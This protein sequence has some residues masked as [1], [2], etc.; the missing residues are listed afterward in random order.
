MS[1]DPPVPSSS[2][3]WLIHVALALV[4]ILAVGFRFFELG[5][6]LR[7]QPE[8]DEHP[9]V[10]NAARMAFDHSLDH[11]YYY[12]PGLAFEIFAVALGLRGTPRDPDPGAYLV[13]RAVLAA[14]SSA[15]VAL[16]YLLGRTR[17]GV[18]AGLS[19]ALFLAISPVDIFVP[20]KVR[21]DAM[22]GTFS[23]LTLL[24]LGSLGNKRGDARAGAALGAASA[25]KFTAILLLPSVLLS[26]L[27]LPRRRWSTLA[28]VFSVASLVF[29]AVTPYA[30]VNAREFVGGMKGQF[31]QHYTERVMTYSGMLLVYLA[32]I[33]KAFG[34]VVAALALLALPLAAVDYRRWAPLIA[35]PLAAILTFSTSDV[36]H[37]RFLAPALGVVALLA[38][39]L[40]QWVARR[41][42]PAAIALALVAAAF[43][44]ERALVQARDLSRPG[45]MDRVADW[46]AAT[47]SPGARLLTLVPELGLDTTRFEVVRLNVSPKLQR[48]WLTLGPYIARETD[49]VVANPTNPAHTPT[50]GTLEP[51][52]HAEPDSNLAGPPL[53]V[54]RV[55]DAQ[56]PH[57]DR[58]A[59]SRVELAA[60]ENSAE[61]GN[62]RDERPET[63]W[64]TEE[65]QRPGQWIEA[66]WETPVRLARVVL[67]L[68]TKPQRWG[69]KVEISVTLDGKT[70]KPAFT[71][72]ASGTGGE[73]AG[74]SRPAAQV[75]IIEP[76][77][78]RGVRVRQQ[79]RSDRR[80]AVADLGLDTLGGEASCRAP[81]P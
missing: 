56:R 10:E 37:E 14:M 73:E 65:A 63:V 3:R 36:R 21:P 53:E 58:L 28:I 12:Y 54:F 17:L 59:L 80:W 60:S 74:A 40:I 5:W 33:P 16:V 41:K 44:L 77:C 34:P 61:L 4:L 75:L 26:W 43:P 49:Y 51:V 18:A 39:G 55:P 31:D 68:G 38:G 9:F 8:S 24:A 11:E 19:A 15:S 47:L 78:A 30:I 76:T 32:I 70:W 2:P 7:H 50:V 27:F 1:A 42:V 66:R 81:S 45:T 20:H 79:G 25:V 48:R 23:L 72:L 29:F 13:V 64:L 6:G 35:F 22:L 67:G 71:A 52:F 62:L 69:R 46:T 57:Y